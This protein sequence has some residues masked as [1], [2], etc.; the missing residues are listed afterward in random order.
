MP[1]FEKQIFSYLI[2]TETSP[3]LIQKVDHYGGRWAR[4]L[5]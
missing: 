2:S 1:V 3:A 4:F 5:V